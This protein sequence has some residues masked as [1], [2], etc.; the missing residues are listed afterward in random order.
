MR[1]SSHARCT[2]QIDTFLVGVPH[3]RFLFL[4]RFPVINLDPDMM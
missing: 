4:L 1:C 2:S 3:V